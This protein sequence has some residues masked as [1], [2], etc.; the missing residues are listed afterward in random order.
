MY[1]YV[2]GIINFIDVFKFLFY[3]LRIRIAFEANFHNISFFQLSSVQYIN[4]VEE[5]IR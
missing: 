2:Y 3:M 4:S 1:L 5:E